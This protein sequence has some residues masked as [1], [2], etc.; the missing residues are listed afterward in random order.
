MKWHFASPSPTATSRDS[1]AAEFFAGSESAAA[2]VREAIQNSLDASDDDPN[3]DLE[4][5]FTFRTLVGDVL[6]RY[7]SE[8]YV[9]LT[10]DGNGLS[11]LSRSP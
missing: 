2:L 11:D 8:A 9:H 6:D 1:S 3:T 10:A 5:R 4:V 7:F